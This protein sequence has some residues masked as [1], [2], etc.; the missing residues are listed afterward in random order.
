[1]VRAAT[2]ITLGCGGNSEGATQTNGTSTDY[3]SRAEVG[4]EVIICTNTS[5]IT[6]TLNPV[7]KDSDRVTVKRQSTGG[8]TVVGTIDGESSIILEPRYTAPQLVYTDAAG[9]WSII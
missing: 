7:H 1:M 2:L 4:H 5:D 9:E 8:V 6:I 3:T